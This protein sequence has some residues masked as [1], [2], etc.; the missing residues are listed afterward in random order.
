MAQTQAA[1]GLTPQQWDD[2]FFRE[3]LRNNPFKPYM[4][5][6]TNSIIQVKEDLTKKRGDSLTYA[7]VNKLT[8]T[9]NDG[10]SKLEGNEEALGSRSHKLTVGLRRHGVSVLEFE[11]QESAIGLRNAAKDQLMDWAMETDV[12]RVVTQL[13]SINGVAYGTATETQKDAWLVDNADR[14]LFGAAKSN[15]SSND[16]SASLANIDA[17]NDKL[18]PGALSLMKRMALSASP[19]IRPIR[20]ESENKRFFVVFAHPLAFRD[21]KENA[22]IQQAQREVSVAK[23]NNKLFQG[24]DLYWDGMI[25]HEVDDM[26]TLSGVGAASI[27]VGGV[28]LC[29][30]QALGLGIAKRWNTRVK[31][32]T[33]YGNESGCAVVGIDG[34][35][36]MTFGSGSGDTDDLKD[37]GVLT[38][39]FAAVA[40]S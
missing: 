26:T 15:N 1:T 12:E 2:K 32:E 19:K 27:D 4:G 25:I 20:I 6:G 5:K 17:T 3:Y 39:Y 24:G 28:F 40:D 37:H 35:D 34:L 9:E 38:G 30:A 13:Y 18:T 33:D 36:K 14:V 29:G 7:L 10:T 23:H 11:E 21:L 31:Q 22:T 16:H 8:G